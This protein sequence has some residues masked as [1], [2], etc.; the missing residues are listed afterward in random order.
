VRSRNSAALE[1]ESQNLRINTVGFSP[2]LTDAE[3]ATS[4]GVYE[5]D[6]VAPARQ[7][8]VHEPS[9]STRFDRDDRWRLLRSKQRLEIS[10]RFYRPAKHHLPVTNLAIRRLPRTEI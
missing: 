7:Q 3:S 6:L 2:M 9:F 5:H 1:S 4:C 10:H 8:V